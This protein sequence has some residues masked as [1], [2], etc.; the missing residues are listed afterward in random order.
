MRTVK[1]SVRLVDVYRVKEAAKILYRLLAARPGR[2]NISHRKLPSFKKHQAFIKSKPYKVWYLIRSAGPGFVGAI[3]VTKQDEI[4]VH[5]FKECRGKGCGRQAVNLLMKRH[6][7]VK[8]FLA[9]INPK[10]SRSIQFF[11]DLKFRHI[12]NT[13]E[14]RR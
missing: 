8:R 5:I 3:Y 10:N 1:S 9:N 14:L 7:R 11:K 2:V 13:Y 6:R 4:G 12:Q